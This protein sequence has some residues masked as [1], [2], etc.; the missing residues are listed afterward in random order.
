MG[1]RGSI[2]GLITTVAVLHPKL[3]LASDGMSMPVY[4]DLLLFGVY[5][6][7]QRRKSGRLGMSE[8]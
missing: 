7:W 4:L 8:Y 2:L 6:Y 3:L 5:D 1:A